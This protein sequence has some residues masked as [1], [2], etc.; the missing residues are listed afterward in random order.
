MKEKYE[1][2][3]RVLADYKILTDQLVYVDD[4]LKRWEGGKFVR[5]DTNRPAGKQIVI[6]Y[7]KC[8]M[9]YLLA[10]FVLQPRLHG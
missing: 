3:K 1:N 5:F 7:N 8:T 4:E 6:G 10:S 2:G 9:R